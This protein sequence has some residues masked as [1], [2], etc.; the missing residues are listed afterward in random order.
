VLPDPAFF[1]YALEDGA[2]LDGKLV[3]L[4]DDARTVVLQGGTVLDGRGGR[5]AVTIVVRGN[6]IVELIH[7]AELREFPGATIIDCS[8]AMVMPGMFDLHVHMMGTAEHDRVFSHLS[9]PHG[10]RALRVGFEAYQL[11][12]YGFT[13]IL[14]LGHGDAEHVYGVREAIGEGIIRGPRIY[15]V[16]WYI[17]PTHESESGLPRPFDRQLRVSQHVPTDGPEEITAALR[18]NASDGA[19]WTKFYF[20]PDQRAGEPWYTA[21]ELEHL[22]RESHRLGMRVACHAKS[23]AAVHAAVQAGVDCIEHGPDVVDQ[24]LLELMAKRGTSYVPTLAVYERMIIVAAEFGY[25]AGRV[26]EIR[27]EL[28]GRMENVRAARALGI[29]IGVGSDVGARAG[30]GYLSGRELALLGECG[31]SPMEAMIAATSVSARILGVEDELGSIEPGK[32]GEVLVIDGDP[33]ADIATFQRPAAIRH[34]L[35]AADRLEPARSPRLTA[36]MRSP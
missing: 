4:R 5:A 15:H 26:D 18:T 3:S 30:F 22:V 27:R 25:S 24:P 12:A 2:A 21:G 16:G 29:P 10:I 14:N 11:L 19:D 8:G 34:V 35:Q 33:L 6:R 1:N 9:P 7:H 32:L 36:P 17:A 23:V 31:F 20:T 28:D 13:T